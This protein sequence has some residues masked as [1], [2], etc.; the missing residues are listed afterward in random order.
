MNRIVSVAR[1]HALGRRDALV[2]PVAI[3]AIAFAVNMVMFAGLPAD[4]TEGDPVSGALASIYVA[5]LAFGAVAVNQHFPFALGLSVTR[6]E[7]VAGLSLFGLVQVVVYST[8]L[9]ILQAIEHATG[10]WGI[11]LHFFG[12]GFI[13]KHSIPVQ[14]LVYAVPMLAMTL[15]GSTAGALYLRWRATGLL[16]A[17]T[18]LMLLLGGVAALIGH[19]EAWPA[20]GHWL[21]HTSLLSLA[22]GWPLLLVVL[23]GGS[24]WLAL[25]R[26]TP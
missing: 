1:L 12:L 23:L 21:T 9:V 18:V 22:V 15:V 6:R 4:A 8:L 19:Y 11:H 3:L 26:A 20:V 25:R 10:G 2:W 5:S 13:D 16:S 24:S 7:F 14:F 17:L